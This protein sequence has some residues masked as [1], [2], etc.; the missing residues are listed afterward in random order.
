MKS[1]M[2][3]AFLTNKSYSKNATTSMSPGLALVV[4]KLPSIH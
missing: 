4:M 1:V 3:L 2:T